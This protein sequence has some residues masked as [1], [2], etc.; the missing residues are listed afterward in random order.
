VAVLA[1]TGPSVRL[2]E[3]RL[4]QVSPIVLDA[5]AQLEQALELTSRGQRQ[6][7]G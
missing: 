5:A 2:T 6:Q 7:K 1:V 4:P 3:E